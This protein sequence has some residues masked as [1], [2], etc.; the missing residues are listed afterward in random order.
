MADTVIKD[1]EVCVLKTLLTKLDILGYQDTIV[2]YSDSVGW[3]RISAIKNGVGKELLDTTNIK[4]FFNRAG[5]ILA[6]EEL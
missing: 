3:C 2:Y 1:L 6:Y 4:D 5:E